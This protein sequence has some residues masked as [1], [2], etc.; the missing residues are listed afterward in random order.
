MSVS[1]APPSAKRSSKIPPPRKLPSR[2][3]PAGSQAHEGRPGAHVARDNDPRGVVE[4][5]ADTRVRLP[6]DGPAEEAV[7]VGECGVECAVLVEARHV[8]YGVRAGGPGRG[9]DL[10]VRLDEHDA[11]PQPVLVGVER[12]VERDDPIAAAEG[13]IGHARRR[14]ADDEQLGVEP[15]ARRAD[16]DDPAARVDGGVR[17]LG[18]PAEVELDDAVAA[19][20]R[21]EVAGIRGERAAG[22]EDQGEGEKKTGDDSG[23]E[24]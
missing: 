7:A 14:E 17:E 19:E 22:R 4:D 1:S 15:L 5:P 21:V 6:R 3:P 16:R 23:A 18:R 8:P 20:G 13:R 11:A 9:H 12:I 24:R 2:S 10:P